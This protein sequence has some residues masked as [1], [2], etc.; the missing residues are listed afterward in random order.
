MSLNTPVKSKDFW[1]ANIDSIVLDTNSDELKAWI[2]AD[3]LKPTHKV[4]LGNLQWIDAETVPAFRTIFESKQDVDAEAKKTIPAVEVPELKLAPVIPPVAKLEK[5]YEPTQSSQ[6]FKLYEEKLKAKAQHNE[7]EKKEVKTG[8]KTD[9]KPFVNKATRKRMPEFSGDSVRKVLGFL[10]GC[11][12]TL[13]IALGGSYLWAYYLKSNKVNEKNLVE[14]TILEE[15]LSNDRVGLRLKFAVAE[16][17]LQATNNNQADAKL[18][19]D[20][21]QELNKLQKQYEADRKTTIEKNQIH[22]RDSEFN[23]TAAASSVVLMI[24]FLLG[25]ILFSKNEKQVKFNRPTISPTLQPNNLEEFQTSIQPNTH[26]TAQPNIDSTNAP[27]IHLTTSTNKIESLGEFLESEEYLSVIA[28]VRTINCLLHKSQSAKFTC[29][30][31]SNNFCVECPQTIE[32]IENC[33]PFCKISCQPL[34]TTTSQNLQPPTSQTRVQNGKLKLDTKANSNVSFTIY[35]N[36][37]KKRVGIISIFLI[38]FSFSIS[39]AYF[40]VFQISPMLV[41][42]PVEV[43]PSVVVNQPKPV[44]EN[45]ANDDGL[46]ARDAS[47]EAE[48]ANVPGIT[49]DGRCIDSKSQQVFDCDEAMKNVIIEEATKKKSVSNA[50][51][52]VAEK[53]NVILGSILPSESPIPENTTQEIQTKPQE[54]LGLMDEFLKTEDNRRFL[55]IFAVSFILLFGVMLTGRL[56]RKE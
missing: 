22:L 41:E 1:Q 43:P 24:L 21:T 20:Y 9:L 13:A 29:A 4:K 16:Q 10:G 31:C 19:T 6:T 7:A 5:K 30:D 40:W 48:L 35:D 8:V 23:N 34:F 53:T 49:P 26:S 18:T 56:M 44:S 36:E 25:R 38:A 50:Q 33:C 32:N 46:L 27:N 14:L 11:I 54:N 2:I 28:P 17:Q 51:K 37:P 55:Q 42:K 52:Q 3:K 45:K 15:K 12:L 47:V 39:I